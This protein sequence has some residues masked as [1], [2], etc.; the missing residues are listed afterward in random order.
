MRMG[1][2]LKVFCMRCIRGHW[3]YVFNDVSLDIVGSFSSPAAALNDCEG[4]T[5]YFINLTD[6][7][8]ATSFVEQYN[9]FSKQL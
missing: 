6:I 2:P 3:S 7:I 9:I 8:V 4:P 1:F 5:Q